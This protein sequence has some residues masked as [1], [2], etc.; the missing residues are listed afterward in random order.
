MNGLRKFAA[1]AVFGIVTA[2]FTG[3]A[4]ADE[5]RVRL[6]NYLNP[7][8]H[9]YAG[10][11]GPITVY[12]RFENEVYNWG[13]MTKTLNSISGSHDY[14]FNV[15][16]KDAYDIE[17]ITITMWSTDLFILDQL[18]LYTEGGSRITYWGVDNDAGYCFSSEGADGDN[19]H[20]HDDTA[21]T[22]RAFNR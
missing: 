7:S 11:V 9:S 15:S 5:I 8:A 6:D 21:R 16:G 19:H 20:C 1:L 10:S 18:E 22:S 12:I 14:V 2:G 3:N 13:S 4:Q 17:V